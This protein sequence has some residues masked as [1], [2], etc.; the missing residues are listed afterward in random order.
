MLKQL[1]NLFIKKN[2]RSPNAIE[3]LQLKFKAAQQSGQSGK[4]QV[5]QFPKDRITD[6]RKA[7]SRPPETE[8]IGGIQTTRGLG[9]LFGRQL[10]KTV[11]KGEVIDASFKSGV[12][13]SGKR[14]TMSNDD[15]ADFK[16]KWF[17]R[18]I[19]QNKWQKT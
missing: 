19:Y 1:I 6:W 8:I 9:D 18:I 7:K 10:E 12:D 14:V 5:I 15:Y 4:G 17:N 3:M 11:K 13:T 2:G 16:D